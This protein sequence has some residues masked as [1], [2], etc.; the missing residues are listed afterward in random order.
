MKEG[1]KKKNTSNNKRGTYT[2]T[3]I[4]DELEQRM[5]AK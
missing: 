5:H 1:E 3:H 4:E 2:Q